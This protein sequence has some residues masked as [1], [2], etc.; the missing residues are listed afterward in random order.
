MNIMKKSILIIACLL[1]FIPVFSPLAAL[2]AEDEGTVAGKEEVV[3]AT[4]S[5]TGEGKELYVVNSLDVVEEGKVTDYGSYSSVKNLTDLSEITQSGDEVEMTAPEGKF[6]YQGNKEETELPWEFA[7]TYSMNG[8][9]TA[10]DNLAGAAGEL[11]IQIETDENEAAD[12]AFFENYLLQIS[13]AFDGEKTRNIE[14]EEGMLANA[15]KDIQVTFTV[16][17]EEEAELAVTAD[18][19]AFE[20][21]GIDITAVP[22]NMPIEAPDTDEFTGDILTLADALEEIDRG[23]LEMRNGTRELH[24]GTA[25][26]RRGSASFRE[27]IEALHGGSN[28]LTE[29]SAAIKDA[30]G[31]MESGLSE[32]E[33]VDLGD[34]SMVTGGLNELAGGLREAESGLNSLHEHFGAASEALDGAMNEIPEHDVSEEEIQALVQAGGNPETVSKLAEVYEASLIAKGT[35]N[36]IKEAFV[37]VE[38]TLGTVTESLGMMAASIEEMENE[39]SRF[40]GETDIASPFEELQAG[41]AA[42]SENYQEFHRG[43]VAYTDGVDELA[44]GYQ[45]LDSGIGEL[46]SGTGE[47]ADGTGE[48]REGTYELADAAKDMP[49]QVTEEIDDL[50]N[51]YDRSDFEAISFVSEKNKDVNAVQ[52]VLRTEAIEMVEPE[53][54]EEETEEEKGIWDRFLD[55]FR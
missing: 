33:D 31:A 26:L 40:L 49:E 50:L 46:E 25:A 28:D 21:A 54:R 24:D 5:P 55:L 45:D 38:S 20:L 11:E 47:L 2:A 19:E 39:F 35:Y 12:P 17:P 30:L 53:E 41:I 52:F 1:V 14:T 8:E 15:G 42:L 43:L 10:P 16:L 51:Q 6:Y 32:A 27:G 29:G 23:V 22:Q 13:F 7:I 44:A 3:Y 4:L 37:A 34:M 18:V 48:L 36:E 9:E